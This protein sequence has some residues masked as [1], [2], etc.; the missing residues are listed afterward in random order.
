ML[1]EFI[2]TSRFGE[3]VILAMHLADQQLRVY[4]VAQK[5]HIHLPS[6]G[7][8]KTTLTLVNA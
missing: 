5:G 1:A 4:T 3:L 8:M 2:E 7:V 6:Q